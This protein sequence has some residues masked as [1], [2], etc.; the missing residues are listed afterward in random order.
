[1]SLAA[2]QLAAAENIWIEGEDAKTSDFIKHSWYDKVAKEG[3]SGKQWLSH[4]DNAKPGTA[5]YVFEAKEGGE[6][7][8]WL[9][10][11]HFRVEMD[12]QLNDGEWTPI[13]T[14]DKNVR[15]SM[16]ISPNPDHRYIGWVKIGKVALKKG[17]N[18]LGIKIRSKLANH[19]GIDCMDFSNTG[20]IPSGA[21]K[22]GAE[23]AGAEVADPNAIWVEGED[24]EQSDFKK[25]PWYD[26][27]AKE[28]FSGKEWLSHYDNAAAGTAKYSFEAKKEADYVFWLRCNYFSA[29]MDYQLDGA[30][31]KP[32]DLSDKN[33]RDGMMVSKNPDHRFIG[34]VKLG[35]LHLAQGKHSVSFKIRSKLS[36]HGGIDCF[37]FADPGFVPSGASKP[38]VASAAAGKPDAWFRLV[39]DTDAFSDKSIIDLSGLLHKPAGQFGFLKREGQNL[40]FEKG[41]Q[42]VKFWGVGA[43]LHE[44]ATPEDMATRARYLAKHGVNMVRQH[45]VFAVLGPLK[46]G[47]FDAKKFEQWDRWFA[48]LKKNGIYMTWSV[49]YP[50]LITAEDGYEP[51]L[52]AELEKSGE[53]YGTSGF[54]NFSRKLQDLEFKYVKALLEHVNPYTKLA[55]KDDPA[56]AVLEIH[57]EDCIFWH[58]PLNPLQANKQPQ[59]AKLLRRMFCEWA[60]KKYADDAALQKAWGTNESLAAGELKIYGAWQFQNNLPEVES[61]ARMGDYIR[62]LADTQ[63]EYYARQFKQWRDEA[64]YK[65]VTVTTA[66]QS[67]G[68]VA[69]AANLYSDSLGDMIDRHNYFG[70]GQGS[71]RIVVGKVANATHLS[72]P[73]GGILSSGMQQVEDQPFCM[74]EW[75]SSPP[76][77]WKAEITPLF[78]FYGMGLQGWDVSYHFLNDGNRI[79]DGWPRLSWY[80]S[81]TPHYMGQFPALA[82]AIY[83]GH[84]KEAPLAAAL[85]FK[86]DDLFTGEDALGQAFTASGGAGA[87][88]KVTKGTRVPNEVLAIGR[89]SVAFDGRA[90]E[91]TEWAKYWDPAT[92][93]I[94]SMT[95]E[96]V[97]DAGQ[98]VVSVRSPKTQAVIGFAGGKEF[99][100]PGVK[101]KIATPFCSLIFTA[102][103]DQPLADSK[104]ILI[105]AMARDQQSNTKYSEDG[106][107]LLAIGGPPLLM[108]PVQVTITL[109]GKP[110]AEVNVVDVYGVPT[111]R[112]V[113]LDGASFNIDGTYK[114]YYYEVKR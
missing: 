16:M 38:T 97:W 13:D 57:N 31:W 77:Q 109:K 103:D 100:L 91:K 80:A 44:T 69:Q 74:T 21:V 107:Q 71:H 90:S 63:R 98:R 87:D 7:V 42:P 112:K 55:Y 33:V 12:C 23:E 24:A 43:N 18:K 81:D 19:G 102:L 47:Q 64:G 41:D 101:V 9:R 95:D 10:C 37:T 14:A 22:P 67:G 25:H 92:N 56:L 51:E 30:D 88:Q 83:K 39:A 2:A 106:T 99:D 65:A 84:I 58:G 85:R 108:E 114:T 27:V 113:K 66:W 34:W 1:L 6:Y 8:F 53:L 86:P 79:G 75:T 93:V 26:N 54:V 52:L 4:Y 32:I 29:E 105:T 45:P 104:H 96:L 60:K 76:N 94:R 49:F 73:G 68:P 110:P 62:F 78:A 35:N 111:D 17:E 59:H 50:L 72:T 46:N 89:V 15:D 61:K 11:N 36:N 5:T 40:K 28:G 82:L 70:G 48:E 20:F 3:L